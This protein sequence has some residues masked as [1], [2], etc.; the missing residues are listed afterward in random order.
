MENF[1]SDYLGIPMRRHSHFDMT[2]KGNKITDFAKGIEYSI[3]QRKTGL[4][5][6]DII[7][8]MI[9]SYLQDGIILVAFVESALQEEGSEVDARATGDG[10]AAVGYSPIDFTDRLLLTVQTVLH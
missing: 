1:V 10:V 9:E 3:K 2:L 7:D 8:V 5:V 6:L 4:A